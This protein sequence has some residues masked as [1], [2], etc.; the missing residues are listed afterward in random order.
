[1]LK[2]LKFI[3]LDLYGNNKN[4][5][6]P[7]IMIYE[8]GKTCRYPSTR[9]AARMMGIPSSNIVACLKGRLKT[10][11]GYRWKYAD[12]FCSYGERREGE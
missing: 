6:K 10:A 3:P 5:E 11:G 8:D 7:V 1:M 2:P 9:D 12:D 4:R